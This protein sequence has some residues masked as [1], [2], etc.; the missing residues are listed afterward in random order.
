VAKVIRAGLNLFACHCSQWAPQD[1]SKGLSD[2]ID[3]LFPVLSMKN[4]YQTNKHTTKWESSPPQLRPTDF[5]LKPRGKVPPES[6]YEFLIKESL[7]EEEQPS[8]KITGR[9]TSR[10]PS[11]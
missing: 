3:I 7:E 4:K 2:G 8:S 1:F 10:F 6:K 5:Y 9:R 11:L